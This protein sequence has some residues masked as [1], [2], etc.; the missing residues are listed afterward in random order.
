VRSPEKPKKKRAGFFSWLSK[1]EPAPVPSVTPVKK[2]KKVRKPMTL[3]EMRIA[4]RERIECKKRKKK[5]RLRKIPGF[6]A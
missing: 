4:E 5:L 2:P 3:G 6:D 1:A